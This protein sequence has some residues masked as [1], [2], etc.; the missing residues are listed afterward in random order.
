[1]KRLI[2][3]VLLVSAMCSCGSHKSSMKQKTSIESIGN[4]QR[5]DTTSASEQVNKTENE[6]VAETVEEVTTVYDTDKPTDPGT[7]RPPVKSETKKTKK[8]ESNKQKQEDKSTSLNQSAVVNDNIKAAVQERKEEDKQKDET[9][10]P[11]Q[12][13]GI[14]RA[15]VALNVVIIVGSIIVK[16]KRKGG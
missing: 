7:G 1:M 8:R 16:R 4:H 13:G 12:I 15:L 10:I 5:K 11:Q 3:V 2:F 14:V 9:T 6:N